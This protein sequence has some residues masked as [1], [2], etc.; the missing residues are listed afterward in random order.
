MSEDDEEA[1]LI[2]GVKKISRKI[3]PKTFCFRIPRLRKIHFLILTG[4]VILSLIYYLNQTQS[5]ELKEQK[6][7]IKE[8][9][10]A[11]TFCSAGSSISKTKMTNLLET[12]KPSSKTRTPG[13]VLLVPKTSYSKG[14]FYFI[15]YQKCLKINTNYNL[16]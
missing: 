6:K 4:L 15:F 11:P 2:T 5:D 10:K 8:G 9:L 13:K 7:I 14:I 3:M 12:L 1:D 16:G